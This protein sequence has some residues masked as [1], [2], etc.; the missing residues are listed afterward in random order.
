[1]PI[2]VGSQTDVPGSGDPIVSPWYQDTATKVVHRFA[3]EAARNAWTTRPEGAV[4]YTLDTNT[5]AMWTGATWVALLDADGSVM[6]GTLILGKSAANFDVQGLE[7]YSAGV[8]WS[9][10]D[11]L[12]EPNLALKKIAPALAASEHFIDFWGRTGG[13]TNN[14]IGSVTVVGTSG[15][16]YNTTS[17]PRQKSGGETR[18]I[19]DA[20]ERVRRLGAAGVAWP[21]PRRRHG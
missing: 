6:T 4:A 17:D 12:S 5:F 1:M 18:G 14:L 20:A 21:I 3:T 11:A 10:V 7:L 8:I 2:T 13:G 16:A 15:V 9:A 19:D